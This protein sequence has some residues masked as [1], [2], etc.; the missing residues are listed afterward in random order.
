MRRERIDFIFPDE[1][2]ISKIEINF[3]YLLFK[4]YSNDTD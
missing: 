1:S 3:Y 2:F 4:K